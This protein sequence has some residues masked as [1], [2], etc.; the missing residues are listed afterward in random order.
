MTQQFHSWVYILKKKNHSNS[1]RY[2]Y[3]YSN[4]NYNSQDMEAFQYIQQDITQQQ[5]KN[6][7]MPFAVTW[8]DLEISILSQVSQTDTM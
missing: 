6:K 2:I 5:K 3:V 1:K 8:M 4:I 7:I